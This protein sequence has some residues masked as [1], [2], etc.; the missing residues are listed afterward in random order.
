MIVVVCG[1]SSCGLEKLGKWRRWDWL[2]RSTVRLSGSFALQCV[3]EDA[4][5]FACKKV[6]HVK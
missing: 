2:Y 4:K 5:S 6:N 1:R 3:V